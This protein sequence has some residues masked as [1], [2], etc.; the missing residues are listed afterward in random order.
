MG[1]KIET[2]SILNEEVICS[3]Q[4]WF[5]HIVAEHPIMARNLNAVK[6]TIE[7]PEVIY[8]SSQNEQ[9]KIYFKKSDFSTYNIYT[10]VV[11]KSIENNKSE[12]V[13]AWPQKE[14]KGGIGDEIYHE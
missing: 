11:T 13:S 14:V 7:K 5:G 2:K 10:K 12:V 4:A 6:D 3:A 9:R 8:T 1:N